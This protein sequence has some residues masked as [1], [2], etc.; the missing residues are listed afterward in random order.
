M[1]LGVDT[2]GTFT[3]FVWFDGRELHIHKVPSTPGR[4][5]DAVMQG[6]AEMG[7]PQSFTLNYGT[8]VATN[9]FL[10]RKGARIA[11]LTTAGFEDVLVIPVRR[12]LKKREAVDLV[13]FTLR[14]ITNIVES[15][16]VIIHLPRARA[17]TRFDRAI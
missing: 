10:E 15:S 5:D 7:L 2:G 4:P 16:N 11:L 14:V 12:E 3:D 13:C 8:T 6:I 9:A 17:N 1:I